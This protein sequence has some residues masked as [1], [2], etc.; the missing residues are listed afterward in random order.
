MV[1]ARGRPAHNATV[2]T[3]TGPTKPCLTAALDASDQPEAVAA[4]HMRLGGEARGRGLDGDPRGRVFNSLWQHAASAPARALFTPPARAATVDIGD[5]AVIQD[6]GDL[7]VRAE[8]VRPEGARPPLHAQRLGYDV[9][10][11]DRAFRRHSR[12]ATRRSTTTTASE[13]T[14]PF[15]FPFLRQAQTAAFVNSDGNITFEEEDKC[16]HASA[17]SRGC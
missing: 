6:A 2:H 11:V 5:I 14:V 3:A 9:S 1:A 13:F 7:I 17:T 4:N 10:R 12:L 16:E 8:S 15:C